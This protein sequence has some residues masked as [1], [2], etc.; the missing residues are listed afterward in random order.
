MRF[1]PTPSILIQSSFALFCT[2]KLAVRM[3][4][5]VGSSKYQAF[6]YE[7]LQAIIGAKRLETYALAEKVNLLFSHVMLMF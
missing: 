2:E 6:D 4:N 1:S 5:S 3:K 7:R